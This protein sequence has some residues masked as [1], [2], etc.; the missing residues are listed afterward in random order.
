MAGKAGMLT[1]S[2]GVI[3]EN[4]QSIRVNPWKINF[5]EPSKKLLNNPR[6]IIE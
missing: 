4:P 6:N 3:R 1:D 2:E 5:F